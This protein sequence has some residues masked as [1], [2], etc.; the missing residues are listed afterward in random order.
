MPRILFLGLSIAVLAAPVSAQTDC[1]PTLGGGYT[2]YD[3]DRGA[4]V[5]VSPR[6]GG[7]YSVYDYETGGYRDVSPRAGGGFTEIG[8]AHV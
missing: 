7:G 3:H 8:R 5:D 1:R 4:F 2:C 6:L